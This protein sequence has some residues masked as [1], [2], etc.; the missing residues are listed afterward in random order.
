MKPRPR[1]LLAGTR[2][3]A[4]LLGSFWSEYISARVRG[5]TEET[6]GDARAV[7]TVTILQRLQHHLSPEALAVPIVFT[8]QL[9]TRVL[10]VS[11]GYRDNTQI[12]AVNSRFNIDPEVMAHTLVEEYVHCQQRIDGTDFDAQ[13]RRYEYHERPYEREAKGLATKVL[14]YD[15]PEY[16]AILI[17][18]EQ[19]N[20]LED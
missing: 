11:I 10:A 20:P 8:E 19:E 12:V 7:F 13:R 16:D 15:A 3:E 1:N 2:A 14:G 5:G 6:I 9:Q 4:Q 17:R 18:D